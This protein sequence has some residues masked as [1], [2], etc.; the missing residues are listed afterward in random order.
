MSRQKGAVGEREAAAKLNEV[1]GTNLHRG[2]QYHGGPDSPDLAGDLP[3]LHLEV[4]RVERLSLYKALA[5]ARQDAATDEI[6]VVVHRANNK[7][8]VLIIEV[9]ALPR[10]AAMVAG[11][12][13]CRPAVEA[14]AVE[15]VVNEKGDGNGLSSMSA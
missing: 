15:V 13:T 9:E 5:Q 7:P 2:R 10:L 14:E 1:L 11:Q 8:W 3:G 12:A 4:K 6:P